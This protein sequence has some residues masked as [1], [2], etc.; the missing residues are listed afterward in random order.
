MNKPDLGCLK[1]FIFVV[2]SGFGCG[3]LLL[4]KRTSHGEM[5]FLRG[6]SLFR[7]GIERGPGNTVGL[8][9][10]RAVEDDP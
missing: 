1:P 3:I 6:F 8:G 10:A 7:K 4:F 2:T 9:R 5:L